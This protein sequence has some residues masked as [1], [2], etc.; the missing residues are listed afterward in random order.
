MLNISK[1]YE[2]IVES[3]DDAIM[4]KGLDAIVVSWNAGAEKLFGFTA[5]EMIGESMLK[6]FPSERVSEENFFLEKISRA[7]RIKHFETIRVHKDGSLIDVSVSLSPIIDDMGHIIGA[8]IIARDISNSKQ[9]ERD[10]QA[11]KQAAEDSNQ[12]KTLFLANMSHEI[13]TPLNAIIGL[14]RLVSETQ[15]T[16]KQH[17]YLNNIQKSSEALLKILNDFLDLSKIEAGKVNIERIEFDPVVMLQGVCDLFTVAAEEKGLEIFLDITPETPLTLIGDP[18]RTQQV[19]TNLLSNAVKFTPKGQVYIRMEAEK[20]GENDLMLCITVRDTGIGIRYTVIKNLFEP[21]SQADSSTTRKYGGTGL[22]LTISKQ[23]VELLGGSI[24]AVSQ[25]GFGSTFSFAVPCGKG[26]AYNWSQDSH[27]LKNTRVL[28]V[29]DQEISCVILGSILQSWQ[30]QVETVL[31]A[32]QALE[33]IHRAEQAGSPFDL[34]LVDWQM[35]GMSG[36]DLTYQLEQQAAVDKLKQLPVIIMVTAY[37]KDELVSE[38]REL[39]VHLDAIL[40]KPVVPSSLLN[41]ILHVYHHQGK[42]YELPE[43]KVDVYEL[44]RPLR[45]AR[46]LLVED[47]QLNQQVAVE[48]LEKAGMSVSIA[49]DG[50]EAIQWLKRVDFDAVLMDLQMPVMDG[51]EATRHIRKLHDYNHLPIIA[52]T[53]SAMEND[54]QDCLEAGMNDHVAK[55]INPVDLINTLLRWVKPIAKALEI[56]QDESVDQKDWSE[57]AERLPGFDLKNIIEM[58]PGNQKQ[59][60]S[61]LVEFRK[62][63][64]SDASSIV[65]KITEGD[66]IN[67]KKCLHTLKGI[68]GNLGAKE[69]HQAT[70]ALEAQ[71]ATA[72]NDSLTLVKWIDVFNRTLVTLASIPDEPDIP[73][74][75]SVD[76]EALLQAIIQLDELLANDAFI[77]D[78]LLRQ[79][80]LLLPEETLS[81]FEEM[82]KYILNTDYSSAR[83]ILDEL[84]NKS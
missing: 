83:A 49:S 69:L 74:T 73:V 59:Y 40:T 19:L 8:S 52:M 76:I 34:L 7:E 53:A 22:G 6:I 75:A 50:G 57:L 43:R 16:P 61:L 82:Q 63:L 18:L 26:K 62:Q 4:S 81:E 15:L 35:K 3:S 60:L 64:G 55:P 66:F 48:F 25:L 9:L 32:Q 70:I 80:K 39:S 46:I 21:F 2:S 38:V 84:K 47:N 12:S 5:R 1:Y 77:S 24:T 10:L 72:G 67:A 56:M 20:R 33:K 29:D 51:F 45:K 79:L 23:L 31:S 42:D 27:H 41:T 78:Y 13:R 17:D 44:A 68:A 58:F 54:R 71:F 28:V 65:I 30:F 11:A 36:L 37:S 14:T